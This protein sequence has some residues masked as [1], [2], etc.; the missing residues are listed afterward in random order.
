MV[1]QM[2]EYQY[3][4]MLLSSKKEWITDTHNNVDEFL[5]NN[6]EWKKFI[7]KGYIPYILFI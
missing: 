2:V 1:K 7:L 3:Y 4:E 5:G 6:S